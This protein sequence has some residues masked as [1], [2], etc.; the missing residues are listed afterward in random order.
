MRPI[1]RMILSQSSSVSRKF[2]PDSA[3]FASS[4]AW[5]SSSLDSK[6]TKPPK[7]LNNGQYRPLSLGTRSIWFLEYR[8]YGRGRLIWR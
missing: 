4:F 5:L 7:L 3:F 8:L 2:V 6:G 1:S